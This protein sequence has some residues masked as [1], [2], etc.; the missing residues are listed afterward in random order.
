[1]FVSDLIGKTELD[2]D[3]CNLVLFAAERGH[4]AARVSI[5]ACMLGLMIIC[6]RPLT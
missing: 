6:R 3:F 1:M 2:Q 5:F 4:T